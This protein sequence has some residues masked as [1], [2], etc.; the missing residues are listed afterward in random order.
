METD[1][2]PPR[3]EAICAG[4][5]IHSYLCKQGV[6]LTEPQAEAVARLV[7][8]EMNPLF[9]TVDRL[10]QEVDDLENRILHGEEEE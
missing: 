10:A 4:R 7:D 1:A 9:R 6:Y 8:A 2:T 5:E 3:K